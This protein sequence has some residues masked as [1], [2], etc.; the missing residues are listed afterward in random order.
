MKKAVRGFACAVIPAVLMLLCGCSPFKLLSAGDLIRAPKLTGEN[1]LLQGAFEEAVGSDIVLLSPLS[2]RYRSSYILHDCN[3]DGTDE[4]LVF[5]AA[6]GTDRIV[7]MHLLEEKSGEWISVGDIT[8]SGNEV[9]NVE[10]GNM[11]SDA[12]AEIAVTWTSSDTKKD[13]SISFY[14]LSL[15][16]SSMIDAI[17]PL[18][19]VQVF[20]YYILD[21]DEDGINELFYLFYDTAED[22]AGAYLRL[23]KFSETDTA[24]LP[25]SEVRLN[26]MISSLLSM[27]YDF[28][29]HGIEFFVDCS[30]NENSYFTDIVLYDRS[31]NALN[32]PVEE[33]GKDAVAMTRRTTLS[34]CSDINDDGLIEIPVELTSEESYMKNAE[35]GDVQ[36]LIFTDWQRYEKSSMVSVKKYFVSSV[37]DFKISVNEL[38]EFAYVVYDAASGEIQFRE[39]EVPESDNIIFIIK[40]VSAAENSADAEK[41]YTV[42]ITERGRMMNITP[43][44][45]NTL[46]EKNG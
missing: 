15:S 42:E 19:T 45:I 13:K 37:Y 22:R 33:A 17:N 39:R 26:P 28:T 35:T 12:D 43:S 34:Y 8:G 31:E 20:D 9:Y 5:Y 7:H 24:L 6:G 10:F 16:E 46:I 29:A 25:V 14:K 36:P 23:L 27:K 30:V 1:A 11:D 44:F 40:E 2:G 3:G 38:R 4:A 41:N 32:C 21:A 18:A